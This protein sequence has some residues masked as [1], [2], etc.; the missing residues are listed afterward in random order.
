MAKRKRSSKRASHH[1]GDPSS[2][3]SVATPR[4]PEK[5]RPVAPRPRHLA[6]VAEESRA[7]ARA[8]AAGLI[9][10]GRAAR[11]TSPAESAAARED[12]VPASPPLHRP[13]SPWQVHGPADLFAFFGPLLSAIVGCQAFVVI[14]LGQLIPD[15]SWLALSALFTAMLG[16]DHL[17]IRPLIGRHHRDFLPRLYVLL[18]ASA[19]PAVALLL[20]RRLS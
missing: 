7:S 16:L 5:P 9:I 17:A 3:T 13:R 14:L 15:P 6:P 10:Q 8:A 19:L 18:G 1:R 11:W 12:A 4:P 2:A 20:V